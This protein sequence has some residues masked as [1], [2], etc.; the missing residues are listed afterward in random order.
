MNSAKMHE[1]DMSENSYESCSW[2]M[3]M[4]FTSKKFQ[5]FLTKMLQSTQS[6]HVELRENIHKETK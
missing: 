2:Q 3:Y 4:H 1:M 5:A 6:I